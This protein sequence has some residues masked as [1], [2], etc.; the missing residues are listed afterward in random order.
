V[1]DL[2][3]RSKIISDLYISNSKWITSSEN[4][5]I[6]FIKNLQDF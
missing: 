1:F 5:I 3:Y 4:N 2:D 6:C